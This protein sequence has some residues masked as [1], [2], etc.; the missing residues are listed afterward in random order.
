M[1]NLFLKIETHYFGNFGT[2]QQLALP[3][4]RW[5]ARSFQERFQRKCLLRAIA[6]N[7][8]D[9]QTGSTLI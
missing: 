8:I 2:K 5:R 4:N 9:F 7:F 3:T 1:M 6:C